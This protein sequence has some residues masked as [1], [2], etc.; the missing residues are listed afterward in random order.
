MIDMLWQDHLTKSTNAS[1]VAALPEVER[2]LGSIENSV[3]G[4]FQIEKGKRKPDAPYGH[5]RI[6]C[7]N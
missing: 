5:Q 7:F 2:Q 3:L 6:V 4:R 1:R